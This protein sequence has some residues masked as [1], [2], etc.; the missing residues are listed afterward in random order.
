MRKYSYHL[1]ISICFLLSLV[2]AKSVLATE[3]LYEMTSVQGDP[4]RC[5][6]YVV[7]MQN[8]DYD[9]LVSCRDLLYPVDESVNNYVVW[10]TP[11]RVPQDRREPGPMKLGS[12]SYGKVNFIAKRPFSNIYVTTESNPN[13]KEPTGS[14]VMQAIPKSVPFLDKPTTPTPSPK[15]EAGKPEKAEDV[16]PTTVKSLKDKL[17][18]GFK[19]AGL[20]AVFALVAVGGLVFVLTRPRG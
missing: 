19:R 15:E 12:L 4:A 9:A 6:I 1:I 7:R 17:I 5:L 18:L 16:Q 20:A 11:I 14:I 13:V 3:G 10:A 2:Y 8:L